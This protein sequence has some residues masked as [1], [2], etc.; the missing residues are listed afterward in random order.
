MKTLV[1][2]TDNEN[3]YSVSYE[4]ESQIVLHYP[5]MSKGII[6]WFNTFASVYYAYPEEQEI[7]KLYKDIFSETLYSDYFSTQWDDHTEQLRLIG[8]KS[9]LCDIALNEQWTNPVVIKKINQKYS[10]MIG[11]GRLLAHIIAKKTT[12]EFK[13]IIIDYDCNSLITNWVVEQQLMTDTD[14]SN[15]LKSNNWH[16]EIEC[17]G[18]KG[19]FPYITHLSSHKNSNTSSQQYLIAGKKNYNFIKSKLC[20]KKMI[21]YIHDKH[22]SNIL[23]T[24]NLFD[25]RLCKLD[26]GNFLNANLVR[27][28]S[29]LG[30]SPAVINQWYF[31]TNQTINFDLAHLLFYLRKE[32]TLYYNTKN[33]FITWIEAR[34]HLDKQVCN[35]N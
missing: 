29:Q 24:S 3:A 4:S 13:C 2:T 26:L 18:I 25:I 21:I 28:N 15:C 17:A 22:N 8:H 32:H 14:L 31:H 9:I 7:K 16:I 34:D 30:L 10:I 5:S 23:D 11:S 6:D 35:A 12:K 19:P 1:R 33:N 20:D 27:H